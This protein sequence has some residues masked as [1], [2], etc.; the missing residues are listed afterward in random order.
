MQEN[1]WILAPTTPELYGGNTG[2]SLFLGYLGA[3]TDEARYTETARAALATTRKQT[4]L[5]KDQLKT[6]GVF[7][8]WGSVIYLL[9]HL[10][11]LWNEPALFTEAQEI[12][13]R[14]P[15]MIE[16]DTMLDVLG[17]AAGCIL[18]LMSLYSVS[19]SPE[20][21]ATAIHCGEHLQAK[22]HHRQEG[23]VAWTG[24]MPSPAPLT[25]FSHG[26]AGCAFSLL[27]LAELSGE[28]RFRQLALGALA[29]ER[30]VFSPQEQNWPDF[31]DIEALEDAQSSGDT[32]PHYLVSWCHGAPG[33]GL[34]RLAALRY[35]D[36][37]PIREEIRIALEKTM[38]AGFGLNH[39]LCHGDLGN[40]ETLLI[41]TQKLPDPQYH[42]RLQHFSSVI[43]DSI[44]TNGWLTGVPLGVEAPGLMTGLAGIGYELLRLAMPDCVPSVL[45]AA[46][47]PLK[48]DQ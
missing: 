46:P 20:V 41:A 23:G 31:R 15:D 22:A 2:I 25:G 27:A 11:V 45:L 18:S 7:D 19:P 33:I 29:Y 32:G 10:G 44:E 34:S 8:G 5:M 4:A 43:L 3:L 28:E 12:V 47:P 17:G 38:T 42:E 39:S 30:S 6:I 14:L 37:E 9:S 35:I 26:A 21:L 13:K 1:Q 40:L 36:D 48:L 16:Q 24:A